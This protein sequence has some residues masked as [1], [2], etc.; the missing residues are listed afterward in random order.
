MNDYRLAVSRNIPNYQLSPGVANR[1]IGSSTVRTKPRNGDWRCFNV[2]LG[3]RFLKVG[4]VE[5]GEVEEVDGHNNNLPQPS[6]RK[7]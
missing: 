7:R 3:L 5:T 4:D 1:F 2:I 6:S